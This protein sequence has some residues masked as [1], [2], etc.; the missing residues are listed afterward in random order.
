MASAHKA[1]RSA[2]G[3]Q[4]TSV[5]TR[6]TTQS[7]SGAVGT[8]A[9]L[10][11]GRWI[12][13]RVHPMPSQS[14]SRPH[15]RRKAARRPG[16]PLPHPKPAL[17]C[18]SDGRRAA[19]GADHSPPPKPALTCT[20]HGGRAA[21]GADHSPPP[22]PVLTCTSHGGRAAHGADHSP[23]PKPV[24]TCT[25]TECVE[26]N[27]GV[28]RGRAASGRHFPDVRRAL[29]A[30][31]PVLTAH[32]GPALVGNRALGADFVCR[33]VGEQPEW[34]VRVTDRTYQ[35][36]LDPRSAV[37]TS[38]EADTVCSSV[39]SGHEMVG[40]ARAADGDPPGSADRGHRKLLVALFRYVGREPCG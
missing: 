3:Q 39:R 1:L 13:F 36:T 20:S 5:R 15:R 17:T 10:V 33:W 30:G 21:H 9:D 4:R 35:H 24:L 16:A 22:K 29:G 40:K 14:A 19:H 38:L 8:R 2:V 34:R 26:D 6:K 32:K 27:G 28:R 7:A 23:P 18:T 31:V 12:V 37:T 11:A 25:S